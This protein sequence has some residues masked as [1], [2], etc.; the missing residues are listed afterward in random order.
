MVSTA[1]SDTGSQIYYSAMIQDVM[2]RFNWI[3][4]IV[5]KQYP[6]HSTVASFFVALTEVVRRGIWTIFRVENEHWVSLRYQQ[7]PEVAF[8][9]GKLGERAP[10]QSVSRPTTPLQDCRPSKTGRVYYVWRRFGANRQQTNP[11]N[12]WPSTEEKHQWYGRHLWRE[13]Y[14]K[15]PQRCTYAR[16]YP[17]SLSARD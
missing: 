12:E 15:R 11:P 16:L 7:L 17:E 2:I 8:V 4:Y 1:G 9:Y 14:P 10:H 5:I 6:Q 13:Q 3:I